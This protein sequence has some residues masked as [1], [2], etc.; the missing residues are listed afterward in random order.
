MFCMKPKMKT[1][2]EGN[3]YCA[4]CVKRLG[5]RN[6]N[7]GK[8]NKSASQRRKRT[9]NVDEIADDGLVNGTKDSERARS[10]GRR[11][12]KRLQSNEIEEKLIDDDD[13]AANDSDGDGVVDSVGDDVENENIDDEEIG[14]DKDED[15][16]EDEA[17]N[18]K[19]SEDDTDDEE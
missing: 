5:L 9:F 11:S 4:R 8:N 10:S 6:E 12:N 1:V 15:V 19:K 18:K 7:E 17:D 13:D 16:D 14:S 3:W 2:P